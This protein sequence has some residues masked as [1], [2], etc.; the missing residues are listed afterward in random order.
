M[1]LVNLLIKN[2]VFSRATSWD[3][4][5]TTS[6]NTI[7]TTSRDT[8][9][10]TSRSTYVATLTTSVTTSKTTT[11]T[12]LV[13]S[14]NTS[15]TTSRTTSRSTSGGSH[16]T[17]WTTFWT[18]PVPNYTQNPG[19]S[20]KSTFWKWY[21]DDSTYNHGL[22]RIPDKSGF[23]WWVDAY[24]GYRNDGYSYATAMQWCRDGWIDNREVKECHKGTYYCDRD[25]EYYLC[26]SYSY[27]WSYD[28]H[29]S[30]ATYVNT[31]NSVTTYWTTSWS[32]SWTTRQY[33]S[34]QTTTSWQTSWETVSSANT[35]WTTHYTTNV[36]TEALTSRDTIRTTTINTE[37]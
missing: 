12:S 34:W 17:N 8:S 29:C 30:K 26:G 7:V 16:S 10:L 5:V 32:T 28:R 13:G 11:K 27:Q 33:T 6:W 4:H 31:S 21:H 19:G 14:H 36:D 3:T 24:W 22:R 37:I 2:N 23:N 35:H 9:N 25:H 15:R 18:A 1:A 20:P